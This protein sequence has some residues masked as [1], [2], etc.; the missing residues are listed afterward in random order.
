VAGIDYPSTENGDSVAGMRAI[1]RR[2]QILVCLYAKHINVRGQQ[3]L[4]DRLDRAFTKL[5]VGSAVRD[6][7]KRPELRIGRDHELP[8]EPKWMNEPDVIA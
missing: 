7:E 5:F 4:L 2:H 8:I 3:T 1:S 6:R